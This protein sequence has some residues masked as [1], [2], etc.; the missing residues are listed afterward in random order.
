MKSDYRLYYTLSPFALQQRQGTGSSEE[1]SNDKPR[2]VL[3]AT[4]S[5]DVYTMLKL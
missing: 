4:R 1:E 3:F 2:N 5:Y